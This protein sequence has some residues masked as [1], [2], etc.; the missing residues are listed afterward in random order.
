MILDVLMYM[1][2]YYLEQQFCDSNDWLNEAGLAEAGFDMNES[3]LAFSW[4]HNWTTWQY[5]HPHNGH[6]RVYSPLEQRL[7]TKDA[8]R[9]L[10]QLQEMKI[11]DQA[12]IEGLLVQIVILESPPLDE[13][14]LNR[15]V[16][17]G[18]LGSGEQAE[19][20]L[21]YTLLAYLSEFEN[22]AV[23]WQ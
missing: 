2:D 18:L 6:W 4:M 12:F 1:A 13:V 11:I 5:Q 7:L 23:T 10:T 3:Q 9:H 14:Q 17:L 15:L 22:D 16:F 8:W 21:S 20:L 19:A